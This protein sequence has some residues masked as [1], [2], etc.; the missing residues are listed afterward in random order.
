[1]SYFRRA[2][3][4]LLPL[5]L[6][7][8]AA[9]CSA[10]S[11]DDVATS[12]DSNLNEDATVHF[13]S[14]GVDS[15]GTFAA[16]GT[17]HVDYDANR[18]TT[19]RGGNDNGS[20]GWTITGYYRINGGDIQSFWAGGFS[21]TGETTQPSIH[22]GDA[23]DLE[24][25]F[26][27]TSRWGC[28]AYDSANGANYHFKVG[29]TANAPGWMG[30]F[31]V[32]MSHECEGGRGAA[33]DRDR[34]A[35]DGSFTYDTWTRQ[36]AATAALYFEVWK[37]GVTDADNPD[38]WKELDVR[39]YSRVGDSGPFAMQYV[40]YDQRVGNNARYMID[41]RPLDPILGLVTIN[42]KS[43]CPSFPLTA[44]GDGY[45][46]ADFQYYIVVNGA[47]LR[48]QGGGVFHGTYQNYKDA[49]APCL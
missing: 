3:T 39:L 15:S 28:S 8:F 47:E 23:G 24:M 2:A 22:L 16:G 38:L 10:S 34:Q 4:F 14:N 35:S 42:D 48:P 26:Q 5:A 40:Q 7:P 45:V 21:P 30:N 41:L 19:C 25:W 33:C 36:R 27:N 17:L 29:A 20:P 43:G 1:M 49:Y 32:V 9:G 13:R 12:T 46:K 18:L 11:G 37:S 31:S 44:D 6:L